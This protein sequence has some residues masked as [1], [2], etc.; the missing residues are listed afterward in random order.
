ARFDE[1]QDQLSHR[2]LAAPRLADEAQ[3]LAGSNRERDPVDGLHGPDRATQQPAL[4]REMLC[5][6]IDLEHRRAHAGCQHATAWSIPVDTSGG[7]S[8]WQRA[9]A[10]PQRGAKAQPGMRSFS[11]GTMPGISLSRRT[12]GASERRR[13]IDAMRP[14]V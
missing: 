11:V 2:R 7:A 10:Y 6:V 1:A 14:R 13:G 3:R 5:E 12:S 8:A 9:S 4:H